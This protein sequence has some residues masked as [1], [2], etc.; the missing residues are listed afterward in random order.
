MPCQEERHGDTPLLVASVAVPGAPV[1]EQEPETPVMCSVWMEAHIQA[2][3]QQLRLDMASRALKL[4]QNAANLVLQPGGG[5]GAKPGPKLQCLNVDLELRFSAPTTPPASSKPSM[6]WGSPRQQCTSSFQEVAMEKMKKKKKRKSVKRSK[7]SQRKSRQRW[8]RLSSTGPT[9]KNK[10][11]K[12]STKNW[13]IP[14][15]TSW[16]KRSLPTCSG[17]SG[18]SSLP[19]DMAPWKK[20][21]PWAA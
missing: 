10:K 5:E 13:E 8:K 2:R 15:W 16:W 18:L 3:L 12:S 4:R 17:P 14:K 20:R 6:V 21:T 19:S 11:K 1:K 9:C 7:K